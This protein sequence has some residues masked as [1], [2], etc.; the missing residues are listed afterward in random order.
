MTYTLRPAVLADATALSAFAQATFPQAAPPV[1]PREAVQN[2]V[3]TALDEASFTRYISTGSYSFTLAENERGE[4]IGYTG[5]DHSQPQPSQIPGTAT[6]LSK[7]YLAPT[8]RGSGL[9]G[10]LMELV[11]EQ[12]RA[13]GRDGIYLGT[14]QQN[15]RAQ[16]F[17]EKMGYTIVGTRLFQL[18]AG[19]QAQDFIYYQSLTKS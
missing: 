5:I 3:D 15:Y 17:Y 8:M 10:E 4:I 11:R 7:F 16:K 19:V 13:A 6:Y 1:V 12:A 9:A 14:H 2:F 18:S